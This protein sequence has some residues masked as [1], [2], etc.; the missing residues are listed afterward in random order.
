[1]PQNMLMTTRSIAQRHDFFNTHLV[2]FDLFLQVAL[3]PHLPRAII[4]QKRQKLI[5]DMVLMAS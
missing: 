1:M 5:A 4:L 3:F 2:T